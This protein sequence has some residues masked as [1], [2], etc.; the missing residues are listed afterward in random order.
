MEVTLSV[1]IDSDACGLVFDITR[2]LVLQ[3]AKLST[4]DGTIRH[5][6]YVLLV[7]LL[8]Y[9]LVFDCVERSLLLLELEMNNRPLHLYTTLIH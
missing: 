1:N 2:L 5:S 8:L 4:F 9:R 6:S 7:V 3:K